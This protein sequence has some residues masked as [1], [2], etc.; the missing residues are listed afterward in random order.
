M[1]EK[2]ISRSNEECI[3]ERW[4]FRKSREKLVVELILELIPQSKRFDA[5]GLTSILQE[6]CRKALAKKSGQYKKPA[7]WWNA[8]IKIARDCCIR[9]RR[10]LT[11][12]RGRTTTTTEAILEAERDYKYVRKSLRLEVLESTGQRIGG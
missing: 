8:E 10:A 4:N 1:E 6:I 9:K 2:T 3:N 11:R 7:S 12:L 5:G